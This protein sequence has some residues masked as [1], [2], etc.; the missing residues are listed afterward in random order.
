MLVDLHS[1]HSRRDVFQVH[2]IDAAE[3]VVVRMQL[4][5]SQ[6]DAIGRSMKQFRGFLTYRKVPIA[7]IE[8]M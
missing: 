5:R 2:G 4:R 6:L 8:R 3:N 1:F 7:A